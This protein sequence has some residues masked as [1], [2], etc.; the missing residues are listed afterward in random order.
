MPRKKQYKL[1]LGG[2]YTNKELGAFKVIKHFKNDYKEEKVMI[3][4][5]SS[6]EILERFEDL[7]AWETHEIEDMLQFDA[8]HMNAKYA[9][10]LGYLAKHACIVADIPYTSQESFD[11]TYESIKGVEP[12]KESPKYMVHKCSDTWTYAIRVYFTIKEDID[13]A[14]LV[15]PKSVIDNMGNHD[16]RTK[17]ISENAWAWRI[18]G[19]GFDLDTNH[20]V[21][22]IRSNIPE[23]YKEAF[24]NGFN[25]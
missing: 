21:D 23:Q 19:M 16:R 1:K 12:N 6:G 11:T 20:N 22:L 7:L 25:S 18:I 14:D 2:T 13:E 15:L 8:E 4:R 9:F 3:V 5:Q 10:T 24:D 17:R